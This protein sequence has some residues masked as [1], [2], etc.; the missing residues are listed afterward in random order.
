M[1]GSVEIHS[2]TFLR[3]RA[4]AISEEQAAKLAPYLCS[5]AVRARDRGQGI[6]RALVEAAIADASRS[7]PPGQWLLLQVE[8]SNV[9]ARR[10]YEACGFKLLSD[11][12]CAILLMRRLLIER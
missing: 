12:R 9:A 2:T 3:S 8:A 1:V 4:G 10:L 7:A 6:G 11:P 5:M